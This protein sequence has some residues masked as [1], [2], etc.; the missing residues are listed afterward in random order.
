[1]REYRKELAITIFLTALD[2]KIFAQI[3][4]KIL[5]ADS[6][7]SLS[8]TFSRVLQIS[9]TTPAPTSDQSAIASTTRGRGHGRST[10]G[11]RGGRRCDHYGRNNHTSDKCWD[12]FN[13][14]Q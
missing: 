3:R 12:K 7:P 8:L 1:M 13:R 6:V 10:G 4:G 14:P 5:R 9:T 11:R 2:P